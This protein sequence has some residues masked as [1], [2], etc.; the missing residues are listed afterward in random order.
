MRKHYLSAVALM[1]MVILAAGSVDTGTNT[2]TPSAVAPTNDPVG[3]DNT[4]VGSDN[5]PDL[6]SSNESGP[7]STESSEV[8]GLLAQRMETYEQ[9]TLKWQA[10]RDS[11]AKAEEELVAHSK[12]L[13]K[14]Q[15]NKPSA[16]TF[17]DREWSTVDEKYKT[18]AIL[19]DTDNQT[20]TLRKADGTTVSVPKD[21][22][23]AKSRIYIQNAYDELT[24]YRESFKT[25]E[26]SKREL[27]KEIASI[28][29]TIAAADQPEPRKPQRQDVVA[30]VEAAREKERERQRLAKAEQ[31]RMAAKAAA[32]KAEY[33]LDVN[34]LVLMR[35]TVAATTNSFGG[36]IT[37]VVENRRDRKLNYAQI[38]FNL[39]D[40]SGAQVGSA[41]ANINGLEPGGKW[42]FK[43]TSFGKDF[44]TYKFSELTGF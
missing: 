23:I 22:L 38:T 34:D 12:E 20:V 9:A 26:K 17:E 19:V 16:P 37:G 5:T 2:S 36:T 13:D 42:K 21:Q 6:S 43:A 18:N 35:K 39:Y 24:E 40:D 32:L 41:M 11:R 25:W 30:E 27:D 3:S 8:D 4:P 33:E 14:L 29:E 31:E 7:S 28:S 44:T 10:A 15:T 1:V